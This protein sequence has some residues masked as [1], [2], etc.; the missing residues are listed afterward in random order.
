VGAGAALSVY[1]GPERSGIDWLLDPESPRLREVVAEAEARSPQ[2]ACD[3]DKLAREAEMLARLLR[4]RH[5]GVATG[6]VEAPDEVIA[7]WQTSLARRPKTWGAAVAE[8]Q[9]ALRDALQDEHIRLRGAPTRPG[10][11]EPG[12]AV[13]ESVVDGV[14]VLHVRRLIGGREDEALLALWSESGDRHFAFDRIVLDLRGN[15]GGNDGHTF[16]WARRRFRA[17]PLHVRGSRWEVRG[18]SLGSWNAFAWRA[19]DANVPVP[20]HLVAGKHDPGPG[21]RIELRH[22]DWPLE[23]GDHRWDGQLL[24]LVDE[25]T[26]SSGESSAWMLHD[27]LGARLLGAP[28]TGMIEFGNI[29]PYVLPGSGLVIDLPTK[30]NDYGFPVESVGFPV[31]AHLPDDVSAADVASEFESFV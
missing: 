28:T 20:P 6:R 27:G 25:R 14:L 31:D 30:H 8:L 13:E 26:R 3:V 16:E 10:E 17:V 18:K 9:L 29:V 11:D 19:V 21:D 22:E 23:A 5:F 15:S 2:T 24:V 7:A 4:E 12:P 1:L